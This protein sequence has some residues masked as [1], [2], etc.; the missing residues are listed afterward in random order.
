MATWTRRV[1]TIRRTEFVLPVPAV[2]ADLHQALTAAR[3]HFLKAHG[4]TDAHVVT[5]DALTINVTDQAVVIS[6]DIDADQ[7]TAP[8]VALDQDGGQQ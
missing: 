2:H 3:R 8:R 4:L 5:E 6:Y 1:T 7:P